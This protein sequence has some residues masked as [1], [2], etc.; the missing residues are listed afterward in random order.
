MVPTCP[1]WAAHTVI[2]ALSAEGKMITKDV[3]LA[4]K[5]SLYVINALTAPLLKQRDKG[6][7]RPGSTSLFV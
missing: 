6:V 1:F 3:E 2:D 4:I 7:P 5:T